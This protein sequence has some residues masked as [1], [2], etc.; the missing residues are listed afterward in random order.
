MS[1]GYAA[2]AFC[3]L[4]ISAAALLNHWRSE[5][6]GAINGI[7]VSRSKEHVYISARR[8]F[9]QKNFCNNPSEE[10]CSTF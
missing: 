2:V 9:T 3:S 5:G 7:Y 8:E 1:T 4:H 6:P 10:H